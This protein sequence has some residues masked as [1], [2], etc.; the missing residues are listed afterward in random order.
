M[1]RDSWD[2]LPP[3]ERDVLILNAVY[4]SEPYSMVF[5]YHDGH[6]WRKEG[7]IEVRSNLTPA[8]NLDHCRRHIEVAISLRNLQSQYIHSLTYLLIGDNTPTPDDL[9]VFVTATPSERCLAAYNVLEGST[10][11]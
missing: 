5:L 3:G 1:D 2:L 7:S 6:L 11:S 9:W 10:C 4:N 8:F